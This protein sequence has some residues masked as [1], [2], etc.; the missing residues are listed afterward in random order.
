MPRKRA[1]SVAVAQG[2]IKRRVQ[3]GPKVTSSLATESSL[4]EFERTIK[5]EMA[6]HYKAADYKYKDISE[7]LG[8]T[9]DV[10]KKW[11]QE[12]EMQAR[13]AKIVED[14]VGSTVKFAQLGAFEM[15]E[16]IADIARKADD[17]KTALQ[18]ACEYLDRIGMTKVNKSE[19][20]S[21]Q[22]IREE[23]EVSLVDKGGLI[24]ALADGAPPEV[25]HRAAALM[26]ELFGL[27]AE[28]TDRDVT[29]S[30]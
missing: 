22:T 14:M 26:D 19:S 21:A 9:V 25:L 28:H 18:A 5:R 23:R 10:L 12:P 6:C 4:S 20:M 30:A 3:R 16:I 17:D 8:V 24:D 2:N 29:H 11:F 15:V 13:T 27:V 7:V 1:G